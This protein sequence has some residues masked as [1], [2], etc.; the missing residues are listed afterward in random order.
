M[1]VL[2]E[3][4]ATAGMAKAAARALTSSR[5]WRALPN[6][7]QAAAE[8]A[9]R[10]Y[11]LDVDW[12]SGVLVTSGAPEALSDCLNALVEPGDEVVLIEP[13]YDSYLPILKRA[14]AI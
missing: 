5:P 8:S 9:R 12:K 6:L 10:F 13:L 14:G 3:V 2:A 11:A 1:V 4:A 7:R